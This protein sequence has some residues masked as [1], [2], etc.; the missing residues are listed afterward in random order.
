MPLGTNFSEILI[1][2]QNFSFTKMHLKIS[3]AAILS[4][5]RWVKVSHLMSYWNDSLFSHKLYV[6]YCKSGSICSTCA[7]AG[8]LMRCFAFRA[9]L[10]GILEH[11]LLALG[12]LDQR[13]E[14][15]RLT[16]WE[17]PG[18]RPWM[19]NYIPLF[20]WDVIMHSCLTHWPLGN[21]NEILGP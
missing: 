10:V 5:G 17:F 1:K 2:I 18:V 19:N 6:G 4:R 11:K 12:L 9:A 7:L 20:M 14:W 16:G 21:L 8:G 3:S 15:E 13:M